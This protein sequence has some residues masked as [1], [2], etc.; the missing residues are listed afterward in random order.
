MVSN[1][2]KIVRNCLKNIYEKKLIVSFYSFLKL[3]LSKIINMQKNVLFVTFSICLLVFGQNSTTKSKTTTKVTPKTTTTTVAPKLKTLADSIGYILGVQIGNDIQKNTVTNPSLSGLN[4]GF[5]DAYNNSSKY[6]I[7]EEKFQEYLQT[8][9]QNQQALLS[10][11][12]SDVN[13][14]FFEENGKRQG[15]KKTAS[16]LQYEVIS[17]GTGAKPLATDVVKVF[18]KGTHLDGKEFDGNIGK[19]PIT[20]PLNQVILGWTEGLQL[21]PVGSKFKFYLP[22]SLGYGVNGSPPVIEPNEALIFEVELLGI[23]AP[24]ENIAP[25]LFNPEQEH[26]HSDPNHKH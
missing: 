15:V 23:E 18:Y 11:A 10:K 20:F 9:F 24:K 5:K 6:L 1:L 19:E 7:P 25:Q 13:D 21:M 14:K 4:L 22:P 26:D 8:F 3:S 17:L 12:K 2:E 16:G